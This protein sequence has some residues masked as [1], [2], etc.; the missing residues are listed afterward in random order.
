MLAGIDLGMRIDSLDNEQT[1][2]E[3][4]ETGRTFR[5]NAVLKATAYARH[6]KCWA[7]ADDSGLAVDALGGQP[8][9]HSARFAELAGAG[10]GDA[11]NNAHLLRLLGQVPDERRTARFICVLALADPRG[12]I[13][14]TAE[15]AV[16]GRIA[17]E[18]RGTNGFG[19]DPLFLLP[20]LG[21]TTA[22]LE[23]DQKHAL[24]HRGQA[25]RRLCGLLA[26]YG[27][28]G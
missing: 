18:P 9:V 28:G 15:G 11:D 6:L 3:P 27:L 12:V 24:S 8:G 5:A 7:L 26:R 14:Y 4:D 19:Y 21:R 16:E 20:E 10:R 17:H 25:L 1:D 13:W 22:E 2:L 23:P